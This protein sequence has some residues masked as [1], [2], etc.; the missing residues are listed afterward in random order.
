MEK[1]EVSNSRMK[2]KQFI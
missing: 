2:N 1:C